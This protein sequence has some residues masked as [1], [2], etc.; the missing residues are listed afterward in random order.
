MFLI[1][2]LF[3][4]IHFY[5]FVS[6]NSHIPDNFVVLQSILSLCFLYIAGFII[7]QRIILAIMGFLAVAIAYTMRVCLSV[8]ITEMVA[9]RNATEDA[10]NGLSI[11]PIDPSIPTNSSGSV[12]I[13]VYNY[14]EWTF[15]NIVH[16]LGSFYW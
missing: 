2:H 4:F 7:P 8:A 14:S 3:L 11:C 9:K 1:H 15:H 10:H 12:W 6:C 16:I 13:L 5:C